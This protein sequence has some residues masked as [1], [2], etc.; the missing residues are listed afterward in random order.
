MALLRIQREK[1]KDD[2]WS[3]L[4]YIQQ[5]SGSGALVFARS[6]QTPFCGCGSWLVNLTAPA[7]VAIHPS[8]E[9]G[10]HG[11]FLMCE[12]IERFVAA[13]KTPQIECGPVQTHGGCMVVRVTLPGGELLGVRQPRHARPEQAKS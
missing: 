5:K 3:A 4:D 12:A 10:V 6:T 7:E 2:Q 11:L 8:E 1:Q 13:V 9:N